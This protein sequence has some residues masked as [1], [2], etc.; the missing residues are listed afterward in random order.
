M[1]SFLEIVSEYIEYR[2]V[3]LKRMTVRVQ[4]AQH[5]TQFSPRLLKSVDEWISLRRKQC[6]YGCAF[7]LFLIII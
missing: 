4:A 1:T 5:R 6:E 7:I 2:I 3:S